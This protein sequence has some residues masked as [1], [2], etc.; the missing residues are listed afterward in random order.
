MKEKVKSFTINF[1][2]ILL[3]ILVWMY[4]FHSCNSIKTNEQIYNEAYEEGYNQA[5]TDNG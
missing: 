2:K 4:L 1:V 3:F 5:L